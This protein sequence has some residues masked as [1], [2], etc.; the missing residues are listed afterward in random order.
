MQAKKLVFTFLF[1]NSAIFL[2]VSPPTPSYFGRN[3]QEQSMEQ[4][5]SWEASSSFVRSFPTKMKKENTV[6][7][8]QKHP[9]WAGHFSAGR[10]RKK[11]IQP[12][13]T[14]PS[15]VHRQ[16]FECGKVCSPCPVLPFARTNPDLGFWAGERQEWRA[17]FLVAGRAV[18][19]C[20][21][22]HAALLFIWTC[23]RFSLCGAIP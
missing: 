8:I 23:S 11:D 1:C 2:I 20:L 22:W 18:W 16:V 17:E 13:F 9:S 4:R 7:D 12:G 21:L 15:A 19:L 5:Y 3:P 14:L 6:C 10:K